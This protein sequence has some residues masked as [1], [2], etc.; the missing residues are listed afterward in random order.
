M[1]QVGID[2][3]ESDIVVLAVGTR[4]KIYHLD[5]D[6]K[7]LCGAGEKGKY[8]HVAKATIPH[9]TRCKVCIAAKI[10]THPSRLDLS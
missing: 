9:H 5:D 1:A 7:P 2:D 3:A 6:G 8:R 4:S 10:G